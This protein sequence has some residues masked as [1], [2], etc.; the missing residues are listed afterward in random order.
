[1]TTLGRGQ[2]P[3]LHVCNGVRGDGETLLR[4]MDGR[5]IE[6][7][8]IVKPVVLPTLRVYPYCQYIFRCV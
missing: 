2:P 3:L 1:M 7:R 5:Y 4:S 8:R 6:V